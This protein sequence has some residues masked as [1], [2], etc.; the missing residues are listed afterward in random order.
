MNINQPIPDFSLKDQRGCPHSLGSYRGKIVVVNFWSAECP[1]SERADE[2]LLALAQQFSGR[3]IL[4]PVASN[5]NEA[6][7]LID[8]V[9]QTRGLDFVLMDE[10]SRLASTLGALTTP[11]A[12]VIDQMGILRYQG[13]VDD[14]TFR[15]RQPEQFY[16]EQAVK[17]LLAGKLPEIQVTQPY[18]CTIVTFA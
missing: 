1:W 10:E 12:F 11:H 8:Q 18:G 14:V 4:L 13:A 3:V 15:K 9:V 7:G 5:Q 16:V 17:T 2:Y 6:S